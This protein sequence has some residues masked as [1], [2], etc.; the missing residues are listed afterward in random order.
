ML[1]NDQRSKIKY[2]LTQDIIY[3]KLLLVKYIPRED[4]ILAINTL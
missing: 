1:P 2:N 4:G 3:L